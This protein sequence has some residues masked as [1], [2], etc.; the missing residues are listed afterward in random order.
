MAS[1]FVALRFGSTTGQSHAYRAGFR[2][3]VV[4]VNEE[5]GQPV[6]HAEF[7]H[8]FDHAPAR[9]VA[10]SLNETHLPGLISDKTS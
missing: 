3:V 5:T 10:D 7:G 6:T 9:M 1:K 2:W 8:F 4:R